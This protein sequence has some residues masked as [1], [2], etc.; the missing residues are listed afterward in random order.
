MVFGGVR[1]NKRFLPYSFLWVL[2]MDSTSVHNNI[3]KYFVAYSR[4]VLLFRIC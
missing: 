3:V 4:V 2:D 1:V